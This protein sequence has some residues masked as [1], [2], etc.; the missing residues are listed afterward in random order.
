MFRNQSFSI[1]FQFLVIKS[2]IAIQVTSV[3]YKLVTLLVNNKDDPLMKLTSMLLKIPFVIFWLKL[4]DL[5]QLVW[6]KIHDL[7]ALYKSVSDL[8]NLIG[9]SHVVELN[10]GFWLATLIV[11]PMASPNRKC[12]VTPLVGLAKLCIVIQ[13]TPVVSHPTLC[14]GL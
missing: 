3:T 9:W 13:Y 14:S 12:L 6:Q 4:Y 10:A 2:F 11:L 5:C 7:L 8:S 1:K